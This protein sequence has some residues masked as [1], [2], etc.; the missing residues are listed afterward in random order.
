MLA[1]PGE[2]G[3]FDL[4]YYHSNHGSMWERKRNY[5][6]FLLKLKHPRPPR[7]I[8][9]P[10]VISSVKEELSSRIDLPRPRI[11][12][13]LSAARR[14][15][16]LDY[17]KRNLSCQKY[18][19]IIKFLLEKFEFFYNII[20]TSLPEDERKAKKIYRVF[21]RQKNVLYFPTAEIS[22]LCALIFLSDLVITPETAVVHLASCFDKKVVAF[23]HSF[24]QATIWRPFS[25]KYISLV[26]PLPGVLNTLPVRTIT[27]ALEKALPVSENIR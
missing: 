18:V 11:L 2:N 21:L 14:E 25:K 1:H 3:N 12:L 7:I 23:Y 26:A 20:L 9:S 27:Q 8:L 10:E 17:L 24:R 13:N 5:I 16:Y 15:N 4:V 22:S 19:K 6:Q